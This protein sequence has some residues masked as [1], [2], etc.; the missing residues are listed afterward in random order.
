MSLPL[1]PLRFVGTEILREGEMQR[2]PVSVAGGL[3]TEGPLHD[4]DLSGYLVLP[5]IIDLHGDGFERHI[6]PRPS[7]PFPL[8][9]GL[10]AT[11]REAAAHGVTT[12]YLAQGW[13]WEGGHRGPDHA[14]R[15]FRA[16]DAYRPKAMTDLRIQVRAEVHLVDTGDRLVE[17]VRR[18]GITYVVFN[19]HLAEAFQKHRENPADFAIW[20]R[21]AGSSPERLHTA[22]RRVSGVAGQV[23]RHLCRLAAAF[24]A[25]GVDYGSHDDA[26][27]ESRERYRM[28]GARIA[29]FPLTRSAAMAAHATGCPV[30]MGAPNVVRGAVRPE[31]SV[32]GI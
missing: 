10:A 13:S 31:M 14:E 30:I 1:P 18:H 9:A 22:M 4:V 21:N 16:L 20:A 29:E 8:A 26:D 7:A 24:D 23:P 28:I 2:R 25:M 17:A 19:D 15:L 12:A 6:A 3:I 27:G 11:D 5:G 32:C